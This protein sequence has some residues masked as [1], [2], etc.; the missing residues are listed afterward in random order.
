MLE[1]RILN[2]LHQGA[3]LTLDAERITLGS[4]LEADIELIDPGIEKK[5][6]TIEFL[7]DRET[8]YINAL[9]GDITAGGEN[10]RVNVIEVNR[11]LVLKVG[12][13]YV[14]FF[15]P[16]DSWDIDLY[17]RAQVV[18]IGSKPR[19]SIL[20]DFKAYIGASA[21]IGSLLTYAIADE[22]KDAQEQKL[23]AL[24][25]DTTA[26]SQQLLSG[27]LQQVD[28][29]ID[30]ESQLKHMLRQ[31]S[32]H[33]KVSVSQAGNR[34]DLTGSLSVD[35]LDTVSRMVLRFKASYPDV[36]LVDSTKPIA[37][38]LPFE[39]RSVS[40]GLHAHVLTTNGER[41]YE[42]DT[43]HGFL[44]KKIEKDKIL[45]SGESDVELLW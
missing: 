33:R 24:S 29:A 44:L 21:I 15:A 28:M 27:H 22:G 18:P 40:S 20:N 8:W 3:A 26:Q 41:V 31:R 1:I 43:I 37:Q 16:E 13:V 30:V 32:L 39:I 9:E 11:G 36:E 19:K 34:W 12:P 14:G 38:A 10:K 7:E 4:S 6:C 23:Q 25:G 5:H 17:S 2:G 45:F 35:E 42:G